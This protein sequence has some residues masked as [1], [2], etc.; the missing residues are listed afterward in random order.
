MPGSEVNF[1]IVVDHRKRIALGTICSASLGDVVLLEEAQC[2]AGDDEYVALH[3]SCGAV[4][5]RLF[6]Q[7][8]YR[9]SLRRA[10]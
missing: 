10:C 3:D 8:V 5:R 7:V 1:R 6:A 9:P 2:D 4:E